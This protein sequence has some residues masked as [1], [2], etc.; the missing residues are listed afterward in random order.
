[1]KIRKLSFAPIQTKKKIMFLFFS[2]IIFIRST[3]HKSIFEIKKNIESCFE[4]L[5]TCLRTIE[6]Q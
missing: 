1:M 6:I 2:Q 4:I 5:D 3:L